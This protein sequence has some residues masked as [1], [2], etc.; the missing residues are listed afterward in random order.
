MLRRV[1]FAVFAV[2]LSALPAAAAEQILFYGSDIVVEQSGDLVVTETIRVRAEGG[3]IKRG[4]FRDFP[5]RNVEPNGLYTKVGFEILEILRDGKAEPY[6]TER[7]ND[8]VRIY[9]GDANVFIETGEYLY[10]IRYRTTRQIRF[11]KDYDELF[12][13]VTGTRWSF[14][15]MRAVATIHL[16]VGAE[17]MQSA[18]YTGGYGASGS[19][20]RVTASSNSQIQFEATRILLAG[21]GLTVAVGFRK[22]ILDAP[23]ESD[24]FL[25]Q[26]LDNLGFVLMGGGGL[27]LAAFFSLIWASI[28]RDPPRGTIIPLFEPPEGLSPA[29]VSYLHFMGFKSSGSSSTKAFIAALLS[30]AVK[31][32]LTIDDTDKKK[33]AVEKGEGDEYGLPSGERAIW[34]ALLKKRDRFVF[35][36]A[37]GTTVKSAQS[38]FRSALLREHEGIFFKNNVFYVVIGVVFTI[39]AVVGYFVFQLPNEDQV[40]GVLIG[41]ACGA[42]GTFV[43]SAGMRRLL[44]WIPGGGSKLLGI[45]LTVLGAVILIF[46]FL[47]IVGGTSGWGALVSFIALLMGAMNIAFFHLVR[48]PTVVGRKVMDDVE[49]F[50]LYLETAEAE[51]M[52]MKDAPDMSEKL[53]ESYLPYAV[54]LGVEKPWSKALAAHIARTVPNPDTYHYHPYW[55]RGSDF[56]PDRFSTAASGLVSS[57]GASVSSAMPKSSGSSGSGGGGFSGGGGGGGGGGG[58]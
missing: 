22:G 9:I 27:G 38:R 36:R 34:N 56:Q 17:I 30:L 33:I 41:L 49:G 4:I 5:V 52:N 32:R 19:D 39:A 21:E 1:L 54:A 3:E 24:Q 29:A 45:L 2:L 23:S 37:N 12:W 42:G 55:Y 6:H 25:R 58:W 14:P 50:R 40:F 57:I 35:E 11:F 10:T 18:G 44:G 53:F 20:Y 16:P 48:A 28:G 51:R 15:I 31:G 13:N 8:Y 7:I 26:M 47:A 43:F 46:G